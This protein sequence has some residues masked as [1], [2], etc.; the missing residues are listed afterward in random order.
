MGFRSKIVFL[1]LSVDV[2]ITVD[3]TRPPGFSDLRHAPAHGETATWCV[4][5]CKLSALATYRVEQMMV[6]TCLRRERMP[7]TRHPLPSDMMSSYSVLVVVPLHLLVLLLRLPYHV[8]LCGRELTHL[9]TLR[10]NF[11][12]W[13]DSGP[14]S[15]LL[16]LSV[17]LRRW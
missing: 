2:S 16:S 15:Y 6:E 11:P 10:L 7:T 9:F 13:W 12:W 3:S 14:R 5:F 1:F 17:G 8:R 4:C